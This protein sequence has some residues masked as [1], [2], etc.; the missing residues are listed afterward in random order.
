MALLTLSLINTAFHAFANR[1]DPDHA[2]PIGAA[3]WGSTLF[4]YENS[5]DGTFMYR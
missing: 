2:A 5:I 3:W 4:A 1:A